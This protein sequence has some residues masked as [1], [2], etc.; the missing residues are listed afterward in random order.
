MQRSSLEED[1]L[2][3]T[4]N[5]TRTACRSHWRGLAMAALCGAAVGATVALL[6][7]P[8]SGARLRRDLAGQADRLKR[9]AADLYEDATE[10]ATDLAAK[11]KELA[12]KATV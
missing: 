7:A 6:Y 9:K 8:K 10:V 4:M 3:N 1:S 5:D 11:G 12:K 2:M